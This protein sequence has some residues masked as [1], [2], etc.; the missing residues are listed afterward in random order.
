M[1]DL[2][3]ESHL[4][5][6][7]H[8]KTK[9]LVRFLEIERPLAIG[10]LHNLWWWAMDYARDGDLTDFADAEI[11]DA[12]EWRGDPGLF[13]N[14]LAQAGGEA[15]EG[16]LE[17]TADGRRVLHDWV[18]YAGR[19]IAA[20]GI[21]RAAN[22]ARQKAWRDRQRA[23]AEA[24]DADKEAEQRNASVTRYVTRRNGP[25]GPDQT[26]PDRTGP[27]L[28]DATPS[29]AAG[30]TLEGS[31]IPMAAQNGRAVAA[32]VVVGPMKPAPPRRPDLHWDAMV[33][34][35]GYNPRQQGA[36]AE[37]AK[38]NVALK[39]LR[40]ANVEPPE[41]AELVRRYRSLY[42]GTNPSPLAL[43]GNL[44]ALR[45]LSAPDRSTS[46]RAIDHT[47]SAPTGAGP[48]PIVGRR[49][50]DEISPERTPHDQT[51][52]PPP[53]ATRVG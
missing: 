4:N 12:A 18:D 40:E 11:A 49:F 33:A 36:K 48:R 29:G 24:K 25:T 17:Y 6:R 22:A 26:G 7:D 46:R 37:C 23:L 1:G 15:S 52:V 45:T 9:R 16:F 27:P 10:L 21:K 44:A 35:L 39:Q 34:A 32:P 2:W 3:I 38:W 42:P 13:I 43:A 5:L 20:E 47:T 14:G 31:Q 8:P 28:A 53:A 19:L 41:I 50:P 51:S 30:G